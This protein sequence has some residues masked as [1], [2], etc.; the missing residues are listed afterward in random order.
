MSLTN[1]QTF[2]LLTGVMGCLMSLVLFFLRSSYPQ[3]IKGMNEWMLVLLLSFLASLLYGA[4]GHWH[5][6][7]SMALPNFLV[8]STL[9]LQI[10]GTY[11][12]FG[13]TIRRSWMYIILLPSIAFILWTSGKSEYFVARLVFISSL[14][15]VIFCAQLPLLF[16]YRK[17]SVAVHLMLAT[18]LLMSLVMLIRVVTAIVNPPP[19]GIYSY[20]PIQAIYLGTYSF[21]TLLLGVSGTLLASEQLRREMERLLKFDALTGALTRRAALEFGE[22]ELARIQRSRG[23]LSVFMVDIDHFKRINDNYGHQF[24]DAVLTDVVR[25]LHHELRRPAAIGRYGGEEFLVLLPD[26]G[27]EHAARIAQR[28]RSNLSQAAMEPKVTVS[29]GVACATR[30]D[31]LNAIINRADQALYKAK[32]AGRNAVFIEEGD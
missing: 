30:A 4:Q 16:R 1:L 9:L 24:G 10:L 14:T 29:V 20:S 13:V 6:L 18:L 19:I 22:D 12:H 3:S 25:H 2:T 32:N 15:A 7:V 21:G 27:L 23:D 31:T 11:R 5:H 28:M 26:T 17:G 8:V